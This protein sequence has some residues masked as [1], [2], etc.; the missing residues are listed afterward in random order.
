MGPSRTVKIPMRKKPPHAD[1]V[2]ANCGKRIVKK[3]S[4][5]S[6]KSRKVFCTKTCEYAFNRKYNQSHGQRSYLEV[7]IEKQLK[8]KFPKL[9]IKYNIK[10]VIGS[11]LDIYIPLL[12][13]AIEIN[14]IHHY[15]PIYGQDKLDEVKK[16]DRK[17]V[18]ECKKNNIKLYR[19][20]VYKNRRR[21]D[22]DHLKR[23][24]GIIKKHLVLRK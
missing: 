14:G 13:I 6:K 8:T 9:N 19:L 2:C 4:I 24:I 7:F 10:Q 22:E 12:K 18:Y 3:K 1:T 17:K 11:E 15:K 5:I 16:N 21:S 23:V 20:N